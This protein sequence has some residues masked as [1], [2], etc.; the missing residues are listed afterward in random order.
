[1]PYAPDF[2][3]GHLIDALSACPLA[4]I[5]NPVIR[6][7]FGSMRELLLC[8]LCE[9]DSH[10]QPQLLQTFLGLYTCVALYL[11]LCRNAY[12]STRAIEHCKE[13]FARAHLYHMAEPLRSQR[14]HRTMALLT[15]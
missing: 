8:S 6:T 7:A 3:R 14:Y 13:V 15:D 2:D 1:M 5:P 4:H 12:G 10:L 11:E 9:S